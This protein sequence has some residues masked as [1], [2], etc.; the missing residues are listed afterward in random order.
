MH[1]EEVLP[2]HKPGGGNNDQPPE[3][4]PGYEEEQKAEDEIA[5]DK[6]A[7]AEPLIETFGEPNV[8][9][10]FSRTWSL[11]EKG[12]QEIEDDIVNRRCGDE[13]EAFVGGVHIVKNT[14]ADKI[15]GVCQRSIVFMTNLCIHSNPHLTEPQKKDVVHQADF[16]M[17]TLI[18]KLGDN[19]QKVRQSAEDAILAMCNHPAF[20]ARL[21]LGYIMRSAP[22]TNASATAKKTM[23]SNKQI[24]GKYQVLHRILGEVDNLSDGQLEQSLKFTLKGLTHALQDV[25]QP[26]TRCMV[27]LYK[28]IGPSVR[29][30]F[31]ELRQA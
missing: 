22:P 10:I 2:T 17:A 3:Y 14:I 7:I 30:H 6:R 5:P 28:L 21:C 8:K 11:R 15:A 25:R 16:I 12:L 13:A 26:A 1:D 20:G 24:I 4:P 27:E 18:E 19:L 23:N 29:D 31:G 9:N